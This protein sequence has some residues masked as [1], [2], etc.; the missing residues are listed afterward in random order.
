MRP[1]A[2]M[3]WQDIENEAG[4]VTKLCSYQHPNIVQ[5]LRH[6]KIGPYY[7]IDMELCDLNLEMYVERF[8]SEISTVEINF[9]F[10]ME[11]LDLKRTNKTKNTFN[12]LEGITN[13]VVFIHDHNE[14]HRDLKPRNSQYGFTLEIMM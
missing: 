1:F 7:F 12:I 2:H 9:P 4:V 6:G 10:P 3:T 5:V 13:G 8:R 14:I 11:H